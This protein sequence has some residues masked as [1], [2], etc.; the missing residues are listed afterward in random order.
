M[1][2]TKRTFAATFVVGAASAAFAASALGAVTGSGATFPRVAYENFC[3]DSGLC[4][5]TAK[6]STGGITDLSNG[7]VDFAGS[8]AL[9]TP[10]QVGAVTSRGGGVYYFPTLL[11]AI[12]VPTNISGVAGRLK[13]DGKV[14]AGI[15]DGEITTWNNPAIVKTNPGVSLP[16]APITVCVRADG[17]GTSFNFSRYLT[18]VSA[19]FKAK[20]NFG[21]TPPWTAPTIIRQPGNAGVANCVKSN[22]NSIGYVD[23]ADAI[24]AALNG[25]V[26]AIGRQQVVK[27][28][29]K[30]VRKTV[31]LLPSA[32]TI[33][34]AGKIP[35]SK[36]KPDLTIDFSASPIPGAYPIT[37]TTWVLTYANY[38]QA[39]KGGAVGDVK[40]F[41]NY[42]YSAPAQAKLP[43]LG[44]AALPAGVITAAKA[45]LKKVS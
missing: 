11:G 16:G 26:S 28:K 35:A 5:Y 8:D 2:R 30:L 19:S 14:V 37:T 18:K 36:I 3:R 39:G 20:V 15:F 13:L 1:D 25:K 17:S 12:T 31:Y 41:L 6:G 9:L 23:L 45:Q 33:S 34:A 43:S 7:V 10:A 40:N 27:V 38:G 44:F 32:S 24:N 29:K 21:Q 42:V 4:S 22:T